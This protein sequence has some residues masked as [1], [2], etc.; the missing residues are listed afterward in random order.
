[1]EWFTTMFAPLSAW[2]D[3]HPAAVAWLLSWLT[4]LGVTQSIKSFVFPDNLGLDAAKRLSLLV[5]T[6]A[7]GAA[8]YGLWPANVE[9]RAAYAIAC[10]MSAPTAYTALKAF[11]ETIFPTLATNLSW[12]SIQSKKE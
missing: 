9:H 10:G 11:I 4:A 2:A 8:A 12:S 6:I 7:G 5:A 1:M 3:S